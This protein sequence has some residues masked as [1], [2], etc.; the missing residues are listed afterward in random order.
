MNDTDTQ[1]IN[2][3]NQKSERERQNDAFV[4]MSKEDFDTMMCQRFPEIFA[5]RNKPMSETCMCWGFD[6]GPGWRPLLI[7]LCNKID[8][9]GKKLGFAVVA[10]QVKSK[11]ASLRFYFHLKWGDGAKGF[12]FPDTECNLLNYLVQDIVSNAENKSAWTCE[13]C[14]RF[15]KTYKLAGWKRTL[16]VEHAVKESQSKGVPLT[17]LDQEDTDI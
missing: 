2:T 6:I 3:V 11:F 9:L 1:P 8:L 13:I 12:P 15:G 7:D 14:G 10:D 17:E 4:A 5:D 16:C